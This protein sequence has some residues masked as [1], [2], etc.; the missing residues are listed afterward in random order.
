[1]EY[2]YSTQFDCIA[3]NN[4]N[5]GFSFSSTERTSQE[6]V[7]ICQGGIGRAEGNHFKHYAGIAARQDLY[8]GADTEL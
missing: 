7:V 1:M 4:C 2:Q 8:R 3:F 5:Q 6:E